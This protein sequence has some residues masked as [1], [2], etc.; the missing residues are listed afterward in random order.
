VAESPS[1][2]HCGLIGPEEVA[3]ENHQKN[4]AGWRKHHAQALNATSVARESSNQRSTQEK[5]LIF[6]DRKHP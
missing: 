3:A 1:Q 6:K 5:M 2:L 4:C